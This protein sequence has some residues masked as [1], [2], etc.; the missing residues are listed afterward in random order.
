MVNQRFYFIICYLLMVLTS[1]SE[2][3]KLNSNTQFGYEDLWNNYD[4]E[5]NVFMRKYSNDTIRVKIELTKNEREKI[6]QSFSE[7]HFQDLP[8]EIDCSKWGRQPIIY[9]EISLGNSRVKYL[10]NSEDGW[11]CPNGKKFNKIYTIIQDII[12]NKPDVKKLE[13]SDIAYE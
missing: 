1:C 11:F 7:N 13:P 12:L 8:K 9:D 6:L 2:G 3:I 10:H 4:S 5:T